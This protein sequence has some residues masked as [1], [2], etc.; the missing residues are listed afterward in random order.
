MTRRLAGVSDQPAPAPTISD[1]RQAVHD[2]ASPKGG[3][4]QVFSYEEL[5]GVIK[6]SPGLEGFVILSSEG[7]PVWR[8]LSPRL[9]GE[10]LTALLAGARER[11][12]EAMQAGGLGKGS[13]MLVENRDHLVYVTSLDSNFGL[14]LVYNTRVPA[15]EC[16]ARTGILSK[17]TQEFLQWKYPALPPMAAGVSR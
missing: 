5:S 2:A 16:L 15:S 13:G 1:I 12:G 7:L 3:F 6:K 11:A 8:E 9:N 17:T 10:T 4:I 14:V